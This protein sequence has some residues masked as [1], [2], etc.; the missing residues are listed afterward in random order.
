MVIQA[1]LC[2]VTT[3]SPLNIAVTPLLR[4]LKSHVHCL[5]MNLSEVW[6][7]TGSF[8]WP[9]SLS[10]SPESLK[11]EYFFLSH[12]GASIR[13]P[14]SDA[15]NQCVSIP[16]LLQ[17]LQLTVNTCDHQMFSLLGSGA[18]YL[19]I[20]KKKKNSSWHLNSDKNEHLTFVNQVILGRVLPLL[21]WELWELPTHNVRQAQ[22]QAIIILQKYVP[23][24]AGA[25][26]EG[27]GNLHE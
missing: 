27:T 3:D 12:T 5:S 14:S 7:C 21:S 8:L 10:W 11:S 26:P 19:T 16:Q 17:A 15:H 22:Q 9:P 6:L 18:A 1:L 13:V 25:G 2:P 24:V 20:K 23:D 4:Q